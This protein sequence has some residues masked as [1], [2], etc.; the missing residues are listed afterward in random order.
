MHTES[1]VANPPSRTVD[2]RVIGGVTLYPEQITKLGAYAKAHRL[3]RA[4]AI[5][6]LIDLHA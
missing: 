2:R 4:A 6:K 5:R 1:G 3:S